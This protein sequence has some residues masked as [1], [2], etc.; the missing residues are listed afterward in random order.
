MAKYVDAFEFH[1]KFDPVIKA[2]HDLIDAMIVLNSLHAVTGQG[3]QSVP[4]AGSR[5]V[6]LR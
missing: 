5:S 3:V 1:A 6:L 4:G 2:S